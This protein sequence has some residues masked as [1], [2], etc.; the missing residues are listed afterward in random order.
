MRAAWYYMGPEAAK[1]PGVIA[2]QV[3]YAITLRRQLADGLRDRASRLAVFDPSPRGREWSLIAHACRREVRR[4]ER[5]DRR[6]AAQGG[7]A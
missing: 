5:A 6:L 1:A 4:C 7:V 2:D 3:S